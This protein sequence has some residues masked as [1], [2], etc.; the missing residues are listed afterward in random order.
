MKTTTRKHPQQSKKYKV[1][2]NSL[3]KTVVLL[4]LNNIIMELETLKANNN[5]KIPHGALLN[6]AA[7]KVATLT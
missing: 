5:G 3:D 1:R 4:I 2:P 6:I 7:S